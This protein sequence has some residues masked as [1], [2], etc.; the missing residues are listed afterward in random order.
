[1]TA[2]RRTAAPIFLHGDEAQSVVREMWEAVRAFP[3]FLAK[4][5]D[6]I[7]GDELQFVIAGFCRELAAL[8]EVCT[9][10]ATPAPARGAMDYD[11]L[12]TAK[13]FPAQRDLAAAIRAGDV[14]VGVDACAL[15][16]AHKFEPCADGVD[17]TANSSSSTEGN[18]A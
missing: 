16:S 10:V 11:L 7:H 18:V 14:V 13:I 15:L 3:A 17:Q 6:E 2:A 1:M 5:P 9:L 4:V 8:T 12:I